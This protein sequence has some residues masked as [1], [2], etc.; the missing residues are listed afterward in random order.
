MKINNINYITRIKNI[1]NNYRLNPDRLPFG[2]GYKDIVDISER[3]KFNDTLYQEYGRTVN[4]SFFNFRLP[5]PVTING[6]PYKLETFKNREKQGF[7]LLSKD[8][9]IKAVMRTIKTNYPLKWDNSFYSEN[10]DRLEITW[11]ISKGE[12]AGEYLIKEA[13]KKS[14][15]LG[16]EGR[17]S[18][19]ASKINEGAGYPE[20]FYYKMG[21]RA[22]IPKKQK[23]LE[24]AMKIYE[25]TGK[26]NGPDGILMYLD[27]N[28]IK[29]YLDLPEEKG[30]FIPLFSG[31]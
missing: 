1:K 14:Q 15:E 4:L 21:F 11:L 16:C 5:K 6:I 17:V 3:K 20:P 24:E 28:R 7:A 19:Y 25:K 9:E 31:T 18:V 27:E 26:Y 29:E 23:E 2:A 10:K 30:Y 8:S 22:V 12:G 13:V